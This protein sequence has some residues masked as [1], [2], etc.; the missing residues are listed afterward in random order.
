MKS[1][2]VLFVT[3]HWTSP[4]CVTASPNFCTFVPCSCPVQPTPILPYEAQRRA[5][6][7]TKYGLRSAPRL[8]AKRATRHS[9][10]HFRASRHHTDQKY[11]ELS[12]LSR[13]QLATMSQCPRISFRDGFPHAFDNRQSFYTS[14]GSACDVFSICLV[15][16]VHIFLVLSSPV[17]ALAGPEGST[18]RGSPSGKGL[19]PKAELGL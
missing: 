2:G 19:P 17:A 16:F 5:I 15:L 3:V 4:S 10:L 18:D 6:L 1:Y 13:A 7:A 14:H 8:K 11:S 12:A 9:L